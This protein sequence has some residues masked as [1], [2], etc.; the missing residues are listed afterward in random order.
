M[1]RH[2]T[3]TAPR[4]LSELASVPTP[5]QPVHDPWMAAREIALWVKRDDLVHPG[6]PGNKWRKLKYNLA[7]ALEA[8]C[9]VIV[10]FGGA[11]SNHI[12]ATASAG[13]ELG[14]RTVGL[15]RGHKPRQLSPILSHA[16]GCGMELHFV[17]RNTY[18]EK[19]N[20][21]T[22]ARLTRPFGN[23]YVLPEGGSN[24]LALQGVAEL[25]GEIDVPFDV[26][27][28]ACGT[29]GTLAGLALAGE[30]GTDILGVAALK[31]ADF[32]N[33]DV[34]RLL[35]PR[36]KHNWRIDLRYH[37][38]GYARA[39]TSLL[40]FADDFTARHGIPIDRVYVAKMLFGLYD[41]V[42]RGEVAPGTTLL[43]VHTGGVAESAG[44]VRSVRQDT[45]PDWLT[46]W[47]CT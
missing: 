35:G 28:C 32:L 46:E 33:H 13:R 30:S 7:A 36:D 10:T 29:G 41:M 42:A 25:I 34:R 37:F 17:D 44:S 27:A 22:L 19:N 5:V 12:Y 4:E 23:A 8:N 43:A 20:P 24:E 2:P 18:R 3:T 6:I 40:S 21:R 47:R 11:F 14:V 45:A 16:V 38:G 15:I 39:T 31:G 1:T 26:L 9:D